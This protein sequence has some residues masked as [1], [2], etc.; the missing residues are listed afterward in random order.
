MPQ[1]N[2]MIGKEKQRI[3]LKK[4]MK[5]KLQGKEKK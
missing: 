2:L 4:N 3:L 5:E 1:E